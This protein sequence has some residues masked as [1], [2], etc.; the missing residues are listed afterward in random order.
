MTLFLGCGP[1]MMNQPS[2]KSC[3][4]IRKRDETKKNL[5]GAIKLKHKKER[6]LGFQE[7]H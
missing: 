5:K 3:V 1:W 7:N 2:L 6:E 4:S